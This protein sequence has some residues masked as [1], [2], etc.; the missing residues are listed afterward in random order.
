MAKRDDLEIGITLSGACPVFNRLYS[1]FHLH[2]ASM[3]IPDI[4]NLLNVLYLVFFLD[5][6]IIPTNIKRAPETFKEL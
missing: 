1:N 4:L 5:L 2:L 3:G 6:I